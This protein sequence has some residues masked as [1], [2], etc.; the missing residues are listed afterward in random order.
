MMAQRC[1]DL[2]V[3]VVL[4]AACSD[5][6][7][8]DPD[9]GASLDTAPPPGDG[10]VQPDAGTNDLNG[11]DHPGEPAPVQG[12]EDLEYLGAFRL[13]GMDE[14][15]DKRL[16]YSEGVV[17]LD[18]KGN[19]WVASHTYV[20][21][22]APFKVP[23]TLGADL[24]SAPVVDQGSSWV[25][26]TQGVQEQIA[27][28]RNVRGLLRVGSGWLY[29]VQ[30]YYNGDSSHDPVLGYEA[31]GLWKTTH[32]SQATAGYLAE[33][34]E[35][36]KPRLGAS[37]ICGLAGTTNHQQASHGPVAHAF[38][39]DPAKM[40]AKDGTVPTERLLFYPL[41][42]A[43]T[44][45]TDVSAIRGAAF[46]KRALYLFGTKGLGA[47]WYGEPDVGNNHDKCGGGKGY[48]AEDR[49]TWVW[50]ID[51]ADL[52]Q[53]AKNGSSAK[54]APVFSGAMNTLL[55]ITA[56]C[57]AIRGASYD[58]AAGRVYLSTQDFAQGSG[59]PQP[60]IHVLGVKSH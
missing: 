23:A 11:P 19:L 47:H 2:L 55:G 21:Y 26:L 54:I 40:P 15:N 25:D 37:F 7:Q 58:H 3:A 52:E 6:V 24:A 13:K 43:H 34:H 51:P 35:H 33:I 8:S 59:E 10:P 41:G 1:L 22:F 42:E 30:E 49:T 16:G 38:D 53:V 36:W 12:L 57:G 60:A 9:S 28:N 56:S 45:F 29:T 31:N 4:V 5:D 18:E 39:L 17:A 32:H 46:T 50:I 20:D 27:A 44:D 48:H 14:G